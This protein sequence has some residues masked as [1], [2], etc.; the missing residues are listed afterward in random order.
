MARRSVLIIG[1]RGYVG[2]H[3]ARAFL[4]AGW[5]VYTFGPQMDTD[6]LA[7]RAAL[8]HD[9][10]GSIENESE[11]ESAIGRSDADVVVSFAAYSKGRMGLARSGEADAARAFA[12]NVEGFRSLLEAAR[13]CGVRRV[14][15]ASSSVVFGPSRLYAEQPVDESAERRPYT[16]YGL[17]KANAELIA[18]FYRDRHGLDVCA[19]RLPLI[20]GPGCW[21]AGVASHLM[22]AIEDVAA[23]R[24]GTL[25]GSEAQFDLMYVSDTARAFLAAAEHDEPLFSVYNVNGFAT[26]Y[27]AI[28]A[29]LRARRP[30]PAPNFERE[31]TTA[32]DYPLMSADRVAR[33]LGFRPRLDLDAAI[34]AYLVTLSPRMP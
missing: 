16:V 3:A 29:A 1:A 8:I 6:P 25:R 14:V 12:V 31:E 5:R 7:D 15:W 24:R 19:L 2:A 20:F 11:I 10:A 18:Q 28:I 23:G 33:E 21:Y 22:T 26:S 34:D 30:D 13:T 9:I 32:T 4:T 17:T 27:P